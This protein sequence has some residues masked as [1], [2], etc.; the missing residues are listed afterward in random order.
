MSKY[1]PLKSL[2]EDWLKKVIKD[3]NRFY[4]NEPNKRY[5]IDIAAYIGERLLSDFDLRECDCYKLAE[6]AKNLRDYKKYDEDN[7]DETTM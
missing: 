6:Y 7:K 3:W 5:G 4:L 1:K 2:M